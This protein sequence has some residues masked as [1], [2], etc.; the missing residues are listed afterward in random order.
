MEYTYEF[1]PMGYLAQVRTALC[2]QVYSRQLVREANRAGDLAAAALDVDIF[3]VPPGKAGSIIERSM[4]YND[5]AVLKRRQ[6]EMIRSVSWRLLN[7]LVCEMTLRVK[8]GP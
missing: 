4:H 1:G 5:V 3:A 8:V 6:A 7:P 2:L